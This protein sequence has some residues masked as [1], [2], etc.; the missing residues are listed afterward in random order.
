MFANT[1]LPIAVG[2][3]LGAALSVVLVMRSRPSSEQEARQRALL[4]GRHRRALRIGLVAYSVIASIFLIITVAIGDI[5]YIV[6]HGIIALI[7]IG[8]LV[9]FWSAG[10][11]KSKPDQRG[12]V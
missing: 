10:I 12:S 9:R 11:T 4:V 2:L 6:L 7:A 1:V 3:M 5:T 8:G